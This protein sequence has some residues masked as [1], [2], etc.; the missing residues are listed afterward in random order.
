MRYGL[1]LAGGKGTR[2]WPMSREAM[3]KQLIPFRKGKSLIRLA[4]ERISGLIPGERVCICAGKA[5]EALIRAAIP[6]LSP[7][8]FIGEPEGR[9]TLNAIA[10][11]LA[12]IG[13]TDD[14]AVVAVVT[15]DQLIEPEDR[16]Q[17]AVREGLDLVE[18]NTS[19]LMTFGI[20]PAYPATGYGY[21]ELGEPLAGNSRRVT[22][23]KEKPEQRLAQDY[24]DAGSSR[25]LW[26]SGMFVFH[27]RTFLSLVRKYEPE[28]HS[29]LMDILSGKKDLASEYGGLKK[30]SVDFAIMEPASAAAS[31]AKD[32]ELLVS[33][34]M[35]DVAWKDIGS[36][37]SYAEAAPSDADGNA[38]SAERSVLEDSRGVLLASS[39]PDH[40]IAV[41]GCEDLIVVHTPDATL[42]CPKSRA[43][44]IK[45]IHS[46]V[47]ERYGDEYL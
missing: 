4:Y 37:P 33:S 35:M 25:Y 21:L 17:A 19:T 36:W 2:L 6:E 34:L 5:H 9:D 32:K 14:E 18:K 1:I 45:R 15:A 11:S 8:G 27:A 39:D 31:A 16:F 13:K 42:V 20:K 47:K 24:F 30:I 12:L 28:T 22:R 7:G 26:N 10:Y 44:E 43:E 46:L 40:L 23:F 29:R 3:P 41:L 38:V